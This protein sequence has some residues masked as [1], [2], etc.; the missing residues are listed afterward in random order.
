MQEHTKAISLS[1]SEISW[2][3]ADRRAK[4]IGFKERSK[5]IQFLIE[6]DI[7]KNRH[8]YKQILVIILLLILAMMSLVILLKV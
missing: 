5:Y 3:D 8:D 7:H 4:S 1:A 6:R 2:D